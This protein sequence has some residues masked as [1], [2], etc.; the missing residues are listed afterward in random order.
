MW[1]VCS[2][3]PHKW[4]SIN[5]TFK[6]YILVWEHVL[7]ITTR[8]DLVIWLVISCATCTCR[9]KSV[10]PSK[11]VYFTPT[12]RFPP[13]WCK[14]EALPTPLDSKVVLGILS[15]IPSAVLAPGIKVGGLSH[16]GF[17]NDSYNYAC[18]KIT[19]DKTLTNEI[20]VL[21]VKWPRGRRSHKNKG[22]ITTGSPT[23]VLSSTNFF[24]K[25]W[26]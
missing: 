19:K 4:S 14:C 3:N 26:T 11:S 1:E 2:E 17:P 23:P 20:Y 18:C 10:K 7:W 21:K 8:G 25:A 16:N 12:P 5:K 24:Y 13:K 22:R 15:S 6:R 9:R